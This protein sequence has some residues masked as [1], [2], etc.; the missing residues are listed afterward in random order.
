VRRAQPR[1]FQDL[2]YVL[3]QATEPAMMLLGPPG[4]GKS[5]LLRRLDLDLAVDALHAPGDDAPLGVFL[6][7]NR[8]RPP[9]VGEPVPAP[10]E[11]LE[12]EWTRQWPGLCAPRPAARAVPR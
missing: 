11:W 6:P 10:R 4:C 9:R 7:L 2:R 5:T 8:Y 12:Q 3:A 1:S